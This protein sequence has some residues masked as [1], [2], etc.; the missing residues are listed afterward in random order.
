[1]SSPPHPELAPLGKDVG[2]GFDRSLIG[3]V[4]R[5]LV[6]GQ[7]PQSVVPSPSHGQFQTGDHQAA[8]QPIGFTVRVPQVQQQDLA[9]VHD[10]PEAQ[11]VG[12]LAQHQLEPGIEA[13]GADLVQGAFP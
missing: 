11:V 9:L 2:Q 6:N 12:L 1:M 13:E 10:R 3:H 7:V 5:K 8:D 4:P